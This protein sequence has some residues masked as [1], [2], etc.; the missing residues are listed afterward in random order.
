MVEQGFAVCQSRKL[1]VG[2][3]VWPL[4]KLEIGILTFCPLSTFNFG[5]F[6]DCAHCLWF[7]SESGSH[8]SSESMRVQD[9]TGT[10]PRPAS[11]TSGNIACVAAFPSFTKM[12]RQQS[13][14]PE[15]AMVASAC[16]S[17]WSTNLFAVVTS[18]TVLFVIFCWSLATQ[19]AN[20]RGQMFDQLSKYRD[21]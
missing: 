6:R 11:T 19:K 2:N 3:L 7:C 8:P 13:K 4:P 14:S 10:E 12:N 16:L 18:L 17:C 21:F 15:C 9:S 1:H 20:E 5:S